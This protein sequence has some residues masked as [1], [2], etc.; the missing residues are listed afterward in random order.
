MLNYNHNSHIPML[1]GAGVVFLFLFLW[2]MTECILVG[3]F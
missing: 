1:K 3:G 2:E